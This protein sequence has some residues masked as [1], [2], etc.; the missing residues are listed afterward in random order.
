M[1]GIGLAGRQQPQCGLTRFVYCDAQG[2]A[3]EVKLTRSGFALTLDHGQEALENLPLITHELAADEVESLD[4]VRP[5]VEHRYA[6]IANDLLHAPF[7]DVTRSEERRV[8]KECRSRWTRD[9]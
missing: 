4:R 8:G 6:G 1:V 9:H 7:G 2:R 5:F 3:E